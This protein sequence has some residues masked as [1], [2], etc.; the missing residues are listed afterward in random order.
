[1]KKKK[2]EVAKQESRGVFRALD[3]GTATIEAN[4]NLEE[5]SPHSGS[6]E[7]VGDVSFE[8]KGIEQDF[9]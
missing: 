1:M 8:S 6:S 7:A 2:Q 5:I 4:F 3:S 9:D